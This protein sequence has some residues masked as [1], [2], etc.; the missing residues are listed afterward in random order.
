M[1]GTSQCR[2]QPRIGPKGRDAARLHLDPLVYHI[3]PL[4]WVNI[5]AALTHIFEQPSKP[6]VLVMGR[7]AS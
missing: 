3:D 1:I 2:Y 7:V 6:P 4:L 5:A